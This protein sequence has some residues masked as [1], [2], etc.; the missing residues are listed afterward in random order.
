M[1]LGS[2][3]LAMSGFLRKPWRQGCEPSEVPAVSWEVSTRRGGLTGFPPGVCLTSA[4]GVVL[5]RE[6]LEPFSGEHLMRSWELLGKCL[7]ISARQ[8]EF[9][10]W[11]VELSPR[12]SQTHLISQLFVAHPKLP[13]INLQAGG[14]GSDSTFLVSE[15]L[16]LVSPPLVTL[17]LRTF[18][19][20]IFTNSTLHTSHVSQCQCTLRSWM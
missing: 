4:P 19:C 8:R 13:P 12:D 17:T 6:G 1:V 14:G 11:V 16:A 3:T 20:D 5:R 7:R 15:L 9:T 10:L 2:T 18:G